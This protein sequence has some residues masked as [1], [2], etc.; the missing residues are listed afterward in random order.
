M[1]FVFGLLLQVAGFVFRTIIPYILCFCIG[2]YCSAK[3]YGTDDESV[4]RDVDFSASVLSVDSGKEITIKA[5]LLGRAN[6][7]VSLYGIDIP[8]EVHENAT[9]SLQS[10]IANDSSV[11]VTISNGLRIG[12]ADISGVVISNGV[13]CNLEQLRRGWAKTNVSNKEFVEAQEEAKKAG[14]G[15]WKK[16][17]DDE[18]RPFFPWWREEYNNV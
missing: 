5:G 2:W 7:T 3:W 11:K 13:N 17:K 15:I 9:I 14:R 10:M 12:R 8:E 18:R 6:R 1:Y 4:G 16:D